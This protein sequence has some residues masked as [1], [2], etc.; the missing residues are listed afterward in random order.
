MKLLRGTLA[1]ALLLAGIGATEAAVRIAN[2]WGGRIGSYL[3]GYQ[4]LDASGQTVVIDGLCASACTIVL[5][6]IPRHKICVTS[7]ASLAFHAAW[8]FGAH[9][10][11]TNFEA[12]RMLFTMYPVQVQ[13]WIARHG[14]LTP[15]TIVLRGK[16]LHA[17]YRSCQR[18]PILSTSANNRAMP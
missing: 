13:R 6:I 9:R 12:T 16:R 5:A 1:A 2:D 11:I 17:M 3:D 15:R 7:K 14:G 4:E 8:D 10:R 18:N